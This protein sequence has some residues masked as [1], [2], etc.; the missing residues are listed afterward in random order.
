MHGKDSGFDTLSE[1][2]SV[3]RVYTGTIL[4]FRTALAFP[5][6]D[7]PIKWIL[8]PY[9]VVFDLPLSFAV[10]TLLLPYTL[11]SQLIHG[12]FVEAYDNPWAG[13]PDG[14]MHGEEFEIHFHDRKRAGT[15][16]TVSVTIQRRTVEV[17][18]VQIALDSNGDGSSAYRAPVDGS[19]IGLGSAG[20]PS[21]LVQLFPRQP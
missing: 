19:V 6:D 10:D 8:F 20:V 3:P 11:P 1:G 18:E 4:W 14:V 17:Q 2:E 12:S 16:V 13:T 5:P 9:L 21:F 7:E 15:T